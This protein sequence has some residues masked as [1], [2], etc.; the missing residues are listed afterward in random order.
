MGEVRSFYLEIPRDEFAQRFP[1]ERI[2]VSAIDQHHPRPRPDRD[3]V[4]RIA[5][6]RRRETGDATAGPISAAS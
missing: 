2:P 3:G 6:D 5:R 1:R 4:L